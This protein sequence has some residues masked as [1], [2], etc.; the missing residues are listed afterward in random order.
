MFLL[1]IH[2]INVSIQYVADMIIILC[3]I[4]KEYV[5][6]SL[7]QLQ[8]MIDLGRVDTSKPIDLSEICNT[9]LFPFNLDHRPYG[10]HI[11]DEVCWL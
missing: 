4:K 6:L 10:I 7:L 11:T 2:N 3:S 9:K 8:R 1:L 5:P